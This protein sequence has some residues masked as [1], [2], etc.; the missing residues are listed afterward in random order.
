MKNKLCYILIILL[1]IFLGFV[2]YHKSDV[3]S[4]KIELDIENLTPKYI[5]ENISSKISQSLL[6]TPEIKEVA[7]FSSFGKLNLYCKIHP[8]IFDKNKVK[9]DIKQKIEML[10]KDF[11]EFYEIKID[12]KYDIKYTHFLILENSDYFKLNEEAKNILNKLLQER[13]LDTIQIFGKRKIINYIYFSNNDLLN[14]DLSVLDLK[15]IINN[16]NIEKNLIEFKSHDEIF[17]SKL[18]STDDISK[19]N[20]YF[21][22]KNF[23]MKLSDVFKIEKTLLESDEN[24]VFYGD[25]FAI[26]LFIAKKKFYPNLLFWLKLRKYNALSSVKVQ[27]I[28]SLSKIQIYLNDYLDSDSVIQICNSLNKL[29]KNKNIYF[30]EKDVPNNNIFSQNVKNR[31]TVLFDKQDKKSIIDFLEKNNVEYV[32]NSSFNLKL[33]D[34]TLDGLENK[35]KKYQNYINLG[36]KRKNMIEQKIN[37]NKLADYFLNKKEILATLMTYEDGFLLDSYKINEDNIH[38]LLKNNDLDKYIYSKKLK[39]MIDSSLL[40]EKFFKN[41]YQVISRINLKYFTLLQFKTLLSN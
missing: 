40:V 20:L 27:K 36:T 29:S 38:I 30:L 15:D 33:F 5:D 10:S 34:E 9:L 35:I 6:K 8:F 16:N 31:I 14:L 17:S 41:D 18:T 4:I 26:V 2:L 28:N 1:L 25:N 11:R 23:S 32:F 24:A 12:D 21:K 37:E 19:I 13:F 3:Y 7:S 22:D 39:T